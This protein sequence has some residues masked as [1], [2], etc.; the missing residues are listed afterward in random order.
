M[1]MVGIENAELQRGRFARL[2][3]TLEVSRAEAL[4]ILALFRYETQAASIVRANL[5]DLY[6]YAPGNLRRAQASVDA[7]LRCGYIEKEAS[8]AG[9]VYTILG[10]ARAIER[11]RM[12]RERA[13]KAG[14]ASGSRRKK[15]PA[16]A[17]RQ[18]KKSAAP[19]EAALDAA[20][21]KPQP[22]PTDAHQQACH[23]TWLAYARAYEQKTCTL[24][25]RNAKA[26]RHIADAVRAVGQT[27]APDVVRFYVEKIDDPFVAANCWPLDLFI[28]RI[29]AYATM[30]Q[31]GMPI[32][33]ARAQ[34]FSQA[35][36]YAQRQ[37]EILNAN[38]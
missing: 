1:A 22:L 12:L 2:A 30:Q 11:L 35:S 8:A 7:L 17:K 36:S 27:R 19:P 14:L 18:A 38:P 28:R 20:E 32:T 24:P 15:P 23:D 34:S 21:T 16:K 33:Q 37:K 31:R 29:Q 25:L 3:E 10:N 9:F 26:M 5:S 6:A 13:S 4:G